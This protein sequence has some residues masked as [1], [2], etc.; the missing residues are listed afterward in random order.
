MKIRHVIPRALWQPA[1]DQGP[2]VPWAV[3]TWQEEGWLPGNAHHGAQLR[4]GPKRK[5]SRRSLGV[6]IAETCVATTPQHLTIPDAA[7]SREVC[8]HPSQGSP[9]TEVKATRALLCPKSLPSAPSPGAVLVNWDWGVKADAG[10][11]STRSEGRYVLQ[12]E[13]FCSGTLGLQVTHVHK[14]NERG[15][16]WG[17]WKQRA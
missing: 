3:R 7:D 15:G 9:E 5:R 8:P 13:P 14:A 2:S 1:Q 12:V 4:T 10:A 17:R 16:N 11:V 6:A